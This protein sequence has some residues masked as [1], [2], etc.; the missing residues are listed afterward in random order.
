MIKRLSASALV[1]LTVASCK[2]LDEKPATDAVAEE[3]IY[4]PRVIDVNKVKFMTPEQRAE[5]L[6]KGWDKNKAL[7]DHIDPDNVEVKVDMSTDREVN[8]KYAKQFALNVQ[9]KNSKGYGSVSISSQWLKVGDKISF[10][11]ISDDKATFTGWEGDIKEGVVIKGNEISVVMDRPRT[12][13]AV[14]ASN[15]NELNVDSK[16]GEP[17][18]AGTYKRGQKAKWSVTSPYN[19][20]DVERVTTAVTSGVIDLED[21]KTVKIDWQREFMVKASSN[22]LGSVNGGNNWVSQGADTVLEAVA[23]DETIGFVKWEGL[24]GAQATANPLT[25]KVDKPANLKAI[26][27]KRQYNLVVK[28]ENGEVTGAGLQPTGSNAK[29]SVT[30][31]VATDDEAV[32]LAAVP[33]SGVAEMTKDQTINVKWV[34]EFRVKVAKSN[35]E[36][37]TDLG[38]VWVKEGEALQNYEIALIKDEKNP[39]KVYSWTGDIPKEKRGEYPLTVKVT[40]PLELVAN[41]NPVMHNLTFNNEVDNQPDV[42]EHLNTDKAS[43]NVPNIRFVNDGVRMVLD[44]KDLK[45][46]VDGM[47]AVPTAKKVAKDDKS[48]IQTVDFEG[49]KNCVRIRTAFAQAIISPEAGRVVYFGSPDNKTNLLWLNEDYKGTM[50]SKTQAEE[51]WADKGGSR[52]WVAPTLVRPVL[53]GK[54]FPPAYE[55]DGAP[56]KNVIISGDRVIVQHF[57]SD[58]YDCAIERTYQIKKNKLIVDTALVKTEAETHKYLIGPVTLT[59]FVRPDKVTFGKSLSPADHVEGY[60]SLAGD[61]PEFKKNELDEN[62][63]TLEVPREN[64]SDWKFGTYTNFAQLE[65]KNYILNT[66]SKFGKSAVFP[67]KN[68]NV[69]FFVPEDP[70]D[71]VEVGHVGELFELSDDKQTSTVIWELEKR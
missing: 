52:V 21:D 59:Q 51:D 66:Y 56:F 60:A 41:L 61:V 57:S 71:F 30:S 10:E 9:A 20:S 3:S 46:Q 70:T 44:K 40:K 31:P 29:W 11:A 49:W 12:V 67:E 24:E 54:K 32:R 65:F 38:E 27:A 15:E 1:V 45:G 22:D 64:D 17:K 42:F 8:L 6:G 14:F 62:R 68:C 26:F 2:Q 58:A 28:S 23:A 55:V 33:A 63:F 19:I 37:V 7:S 69:T 25:L 4:K 53:T 50:T 47:S 13:Y 39:E 43:H 36:A 48:S 5:K 18:G 16:F 35:G 34:K